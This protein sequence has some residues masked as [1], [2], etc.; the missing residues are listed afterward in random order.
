MMDVMVG[1][2]RGLGYSTVPMIVSLL[3]ACGL[4]ILWLATVFQVQ[5]FQTPFGIINFHTPFGI[6]I[7]YPISW[8]ITFLAHVG[9]YCVIWHM[10]RKKLKKSEVKG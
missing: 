2:M 6:Y 1:M 4:R 3:G 10:V 7:S 8:A 5:E 9:C